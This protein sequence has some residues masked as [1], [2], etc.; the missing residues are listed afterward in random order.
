MVAT[1]NKSD[2]DDMLVMSSSQSNKE[3][4]LDSRCTFH[5]YLKKTKVHLLLWLVLNL[6]VLSGNIIVHNCTFIASE[7]YN[8]TYL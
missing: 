6:Y 5:M 2:T 3:G 4:M 1:E 8:S 7:M